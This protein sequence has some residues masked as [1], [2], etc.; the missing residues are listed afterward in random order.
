MPDLK[1]TLYRIEKFNAEHIDTFDVREEIYS[2]I[3][4]FKKNKDLQALWQYKLP[5]LTLFYKD[6]PILIYGM[7]S[8]GTGT[9]FP[10][11]YAG[12]GIDKHKFAVVRCIYDYADKFVGNDVRRFEASVDALDKKANR[13]VRFFG[14]EPI[15][16]RRQATLDGNDQ[17]IYER[18]WR[19]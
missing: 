6:K 17:I 12:K 9:Y 19:K 16:I 10:M 7:Q 14:M 18:L 4:F 5:I 2:E 8:A 11:A 15:G 1:S 13:F 3:L